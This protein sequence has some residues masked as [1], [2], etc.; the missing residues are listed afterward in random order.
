VPDG[1]FFHPAKAVGVDSRSEAF[2]PHT[3]GFFLCRSLEF[4]KLLEFFP[5]SLELVRL[6]EELREPIIVKF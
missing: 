5:E 3:L 6:T 2:E 4:G 1:V